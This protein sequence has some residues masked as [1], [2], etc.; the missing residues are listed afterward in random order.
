MAGRRTTGSV[1][2]S[3]VAKIRITSFGGIALAGAVAVAVG[4]GLVLHQTLVPQHARGAGVVAR[5]RGATRDVEPRPGARVALRVPDVPWLAE[6]GD[7]VWLHGR[8]AAP[9]RDVLPAGETG[10]GIDERYVATTVPAAGGRSTVRLRDPG[11]GR[12]VRAVDLPIWVSAGAWTRGGLVVTGYRDSSMAWD[13]G[14]VLVTVPDFAVRTLVAPRP[15]PERL[16]APVARGEVVASPSGSIVASNLCGVR[17]CDTQVVDLATGEIFR[18]IQSAEGF[19]RV[20]TDDLIV[21]T[22][23]DY[24]WI[25]GRRFRDGSEAWHQTDSMLLDPL[26]A[27]DGAVV[28]VVGSR[29]AGWGVAAFD[30][31]GRVR[32]LTSR[33]GADRPWPRI[34]RQLSTPT[35]AVVG[36]EGFEDAVRTTLGSPEAV[37]PVVALPA[38]PEVTP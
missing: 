7:G 22:D 2:T 28:G 38:A 36:R 35:T 4:G 16:G 33:T 9:T 5:D 24:G 15:Y 3:H 8:G 12:L 19:L 17:L 20:V 6:R 25:S 34:W 13:G 37:L 14:L 30:G 23:D 21:T 26:A 32:N 10:L 18:P 29:V 11:S 31:Q 1:E 27:A